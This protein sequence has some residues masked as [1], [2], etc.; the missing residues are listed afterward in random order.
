M[1][2][3]A[4]SEDTLGIALCAGWVNL[5]DEQRRR[6]YE[7]DIFHGALSMAIGEVTGKRAVTVQESHRL[8]TGFLLDTESS[9]G[10]IGPTHYASVMYSSVSDGMWRL[11]G[12][13]DARGVV[14]D[15]H[16]MLVHHLSQFAIGAFPIEVAAQVAA[17]H[18]DIAVRHD[19]R[20][21]RA[22]WQLARIETSA[23]PEA[24][25]TM[26]ALRFGALTDIV[27]D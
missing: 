24:V 10:Q 14:A 25:E 23:T 17:D 1:D 4:A 16:E 12:T 11:A 21:F 26:Q 3:V 15:R 22:L 19:G 18:P 7:C 6:A 20:L 2:P 13:G 8:L 9:D 27:E 5:T